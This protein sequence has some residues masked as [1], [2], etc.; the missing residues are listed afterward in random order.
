MKQP[1]LPPKIGKKNP[2]SEQHLTIIGSNNPEIIAEIAKL[3]KEGHIVLSLSKD[4]FNN[5][6]DY[7]S[8]EMRLHHEQMELEAFKKKNVDN[9]NI[10]MHVQKLRTTMG[11]KTYFTMKELVD[12]TNMVYATAKD[13]I[14][15]LEVF[16]YVVVRKGKDNKKEY[17][18]NVTQEEQLAVLNDSIADKAAELDFMEKKRA[19]MFGA[20]I[21]SESNDLTCGE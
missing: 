4:G 8:R 10:F 11:A 19:E 2:V 16:G 3:R 9:F 5:A 17:R 1:P 12:E 15:L 21:L 7:I 20:L 6:K 13:F 14:N 18:L